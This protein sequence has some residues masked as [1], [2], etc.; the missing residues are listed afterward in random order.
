MNRPFDIDK[1]TAAPVESARS[2]QRLVWD[3]PVR[4]FHWSLVAAVITA[5]VTHR[6]GVEY[7]KW[8]LW[9]GYAVIVLVMFR[10]LWGIV[11]TRHARFSNFVRG[12]VATLRYLREL[13]QRQRK[14]HAGHNP[15]GALMVLVLLV[16]LL[17]Q[18]VLGLFGNDE[19]FNVGPLYAYISNELSLKLT[20]LHRQL[21]YWIAGAIGLHV[22]AV[23]IHHVWLRDPLLRAMFTGRKPARSLSEF[24][25]IHSSRL[26]LAAVLVIAV[27]GALAWI[28]V[29]APTAVADIS[30]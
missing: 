21:F 2:G 14:H 19:I 13:R 7:F 16:A 27:I 10:I 8:H 23:L 12:P 28:I 30:Y 17:T 3:L 25:G 18:A 29:S 4:L 5:F 6:L 24:D 22:L 26:G 15:L 1:A 9:S 11:G 20:S